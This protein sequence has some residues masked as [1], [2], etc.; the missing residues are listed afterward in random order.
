MPAFKPEDADWLVCE[1]LNVGDLDATMALYEP[2][3]S[4]GRA[5]AGRHRYRGYS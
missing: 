2:G 4:W 1:A 3:A 5:G